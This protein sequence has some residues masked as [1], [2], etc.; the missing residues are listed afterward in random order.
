MIIKGVLDSGFDRTNTDLASDP[1]VHTGWYN[2]NQG[3]VAISVS[4]AEDG[5]VG[6]GDTGITGMDGGGNTTQIRAGFVL[7]NCWP[8]TRAE[9]SDATTASGTDNPKELAWQMALEVV[10]TIGS[11]GSGTTHPSTG[12]QELNS[13][14]PGTKRRVADDAGEETRYRY[15]VPILYSYGLRHS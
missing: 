7:V 9:T 6:G 12:E 1:P 2:Y 5:P 3:G 4:N 11:N 15:E 13:L 14:A 10:K 8:G